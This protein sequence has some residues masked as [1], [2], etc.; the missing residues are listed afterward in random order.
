VCSQT[1]SSSPKL[2]QTFQSATL[3]C[4]VIFQGAAST[5]PTDQLD[6]P[7]V[8]KQPTNQ[9][10]LPSMRMAPLHDTSIT[11]ET[12]Y[13][14]NIQKTFPKAVSTTDNQNIYTHAQKYI[15]QGTSNPADFSGSYPTKSGYIA[16]AE[17]HIVSLNCFVFDK[18][19]Y[20]AYLC[21]EEPSQETQVFFHDCV[22]SLH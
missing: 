22:I 20:C 5:G 10:N 21:W 9:I 11:E 6:E 18:H 8:L 1:T 4:F 16:H 3:F 17:T 19:Q 13:P 12:K 15:Y 2:Y 14:E 7:G